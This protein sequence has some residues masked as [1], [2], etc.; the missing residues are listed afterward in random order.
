MRRFK[1]VE[2]C[3]IPQHFSMSLP[4]RYFRQVAFLVSKKTQVE[5]PFETIAAR[6]AATS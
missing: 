3:A 2:E 4:Y 6:A 1:K 5:R